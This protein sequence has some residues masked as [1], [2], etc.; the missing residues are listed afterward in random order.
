MEVTGKHYALVCHHGIVEP[1]PIVVGE[2]NDNSVLVVS[3]LR[4]GERV[5]STSAQRNVQP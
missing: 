2:T 3:G 1:R 4:E 5:A